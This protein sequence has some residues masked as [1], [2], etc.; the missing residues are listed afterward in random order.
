MRG[1]Q[2]VAVVVAAVAVAG[3]VAG[4]VLVLAGPAAPHGGAVSSLASAGRAS[5]LGV[6]AA[7]PPAPTRR[8]RR[9]RRAATPSAV[10]FGELLVEVANAHARAHGD[11]AQIARPDC[12]QASPGRYMCS[13]SVDEPG[14]RSECHLMQA[15]WTP[16]KAPAITVTLAGRTRRCGTLREAIASLE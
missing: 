3:G 2:V 10:E 12:V 8:E 11:P 13:Y 5:R 16:R 4:A 15:R 7:R 9:A 6:A 14:R 1:T